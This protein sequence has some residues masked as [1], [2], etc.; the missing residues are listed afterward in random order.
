MTKA[1]ILIVAL[2]M[3]ADLLTFSL[4]V[5]LVG[6][7]AESNPIMA[8]GYATFGLVMVILLKAAVTVAIC[9][10]LFRVRTTGLRVLTAVFAASFG[11]LGTLGNVTA[12]L[13]L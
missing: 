9:G 1:L 13:R 3:G 11:L 5:P 7:E 6:I 4:V 8:A 12:W 10:L 2:A